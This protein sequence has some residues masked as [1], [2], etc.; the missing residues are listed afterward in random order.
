MTD[1]K[2]AAEATTKDTKAGENKKDHKKKVQKK[3]VQ[4]AHAKRVARVNKKGK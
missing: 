4:V 3:K 1:N 2:K